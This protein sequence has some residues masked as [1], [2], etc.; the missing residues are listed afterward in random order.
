MMKR[1]FDI[2]FS[3]CML[4]V[5]LPLFLVIALSIV[6]DSRGGVFFGQIRVGKNERAFKLWKFRTMRPGSEKKGQ[7][8]V[9]ARDNRITKT[10]YVLRKYKMDELPQLWN[11]FVGEMSMVGPRPEVPRYVEM[12]S[13][14]QKKVLSIKPGITDYASLLYFSESELLAQSADP[15][16]TYVDEVMPAKLKLNLEYVKDHT[17]ANDLKI[18][19]KTISRIFS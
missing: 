7:L 17:F 8:T 16:R 10:G 5:L 3:A 12:Y 19:G 14:E 9:G 4:L 18:I 1:M 15:E 11:V 2:F 13:A 6:L